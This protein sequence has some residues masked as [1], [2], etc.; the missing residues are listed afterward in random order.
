[1]LGR[2][3]GLQV[4]RRLLVL[5]A[6]DRGDELLERDK[7]ITTRGER[8]VGGDGQERGRLTRGEE[9]L[10]LRGRERGDLLRREHGV[11]GHLRIDALAEGT[12]GPTRPSEGRVQRG[13][14]RRQVVAHRAGEQRV[15]AAP[16]RHRLKFQLGLIQLVASGGELLLERCHLFDELG[17]GA[18]IHHRPLRAGGGSDDEDR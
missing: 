3:P 4:E 18:H 16:A 17:Y 11:R 2:D 14:I 12:I 1:M 10:T 7:S 8:L 9:L 6:P 13:P 15:H 5:R